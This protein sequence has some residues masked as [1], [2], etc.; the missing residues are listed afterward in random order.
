MSKDKKETSIEAEVETEESVE[1]Q[2]DETSEVDK[3]KAQVAEWEDKFLRAHASFENSKRLLEKD[4]AAAVAYANE[5]FAKDILSVI[6]S[7][8]S[9]LSM[10]DNVDEKDNNEF[11]KKM[12]EGL[13][14]VDEQLHKVLEKNHIKNIECDKEYDPNLHQAIMQVDS[15]EHE[16]GQIVQVMQK[17]YTIKDRVLRPAMV[18]TAK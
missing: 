1:V 2:N 16:S 17:G 15:D 5:S 11:L 10:I 14:L 8:D 6:D 12:K 7:L 18:T 9:A 13:T 4:K 3:L